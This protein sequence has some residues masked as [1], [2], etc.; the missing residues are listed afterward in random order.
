MSRRQNQFFTFIL[1]DVYRFV[2]AY[3][4]FATIMVDNTQLDSLPLFNQGIYHTGRVAFILLVCITGARVVRDSS[5]KCIRLYAIL[6][7]GIISSLSGANKWMLELAILVIGLRGTDCDKILRSAYTGLISGCV[8]IILLGASGIISGNTVTRFGATRLSLGFYHPNILGMRFF[9]IIALHLYFQSQKRLRFIDAA[10]AVLMGL[11]IHLT[12]NS[13]TS[14]FLMFVLG[15]AAFAFALNTKKN[16]ANAILTAGVIKS[17]LEWMTMTSFLIPLFAIFGSLTLGKLPQAVGNA[18][19]LWSRFGQSRLYF[20]YY[21]LSWHGRALM[22][23]D[24][25]NAA[26]NMFTL[27]NG[28]MYLLLGFGVLAFSVF[29]IGELLLVFRTYRSEKWM[30]L[31]ILILYLMFGMMETGLI[32]PHCNFFLLLLSEV[33]WEGSSIKDL[34]KKGEKCEYFADRT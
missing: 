16:A 11:F 28:Y 6:F 33:L 21:G 9:Q 7:I 3:W 24:S 8:I 26:Y 13:R 15:A 14:T 32:R 22:N 27:D 25:A 5:Y 29:I 20:D 1:E 18:T 12:A 17:V 31:I 23:K 30:L 19:T 2:I 10:L 34:H 4:Y